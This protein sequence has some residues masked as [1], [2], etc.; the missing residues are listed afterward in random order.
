[1]HGW[2]ND[3]TGPSHRSSSRYCRLTTIRVSGRV[4]LDDNLEVDHTGMVESG[5]HAAG[6]LECLRMTSS[7]PRATD[8]HSASNR[9]RVRCSKILSATAS[10]AFALASFSAL[11]QVASHQPSEANGGGPAHTWLSDAKSYAAAPLRWRGRQWLHFGGVIAA[12]GVAYEY[13]DKTREHFFD[14]EGLDTASSG[15][16]D[17][18]DAL[19]AAIALGGTWLAAALMHDDD[20]RREARAMI[21]AATLSSAAGIIMK[22]AFGRERPN[23]TTDRG[24]WRSGGDSFPSLHVTAAFAIGSV[25]AESGNDRYRWLR[26][27]L[28][29]GIATGTA[30]ARLEHGAHWLSD[31]VAGAALGIATAHFV[32][33]KDTD[34]NRRA[35]ISLAPTDG[36]LMLTYSVYAKP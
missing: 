36:G 2:Y 9:I 4:G 31:T 34:R 10:I 11:A 1:M 35:A 16:H 7:L 25:L 27:I 30:Y 22:Q 17:G 29:Y 15:T 8:R 33:H 32:M 24:S 26:R 19:P 28:G 18:R 12:I 14:G 20:G 6:F 3:C 23:V 5:Y 13:D 21:E